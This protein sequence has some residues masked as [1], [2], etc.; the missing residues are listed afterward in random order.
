MFPGEVA[1]PYHLTSPTVKQRAIVWKY[2]RNAYSVKLVAPPL[3][4]FQ[5]QGKFPFNEIEIINYTLVAAE[6]RAG[7]I[8]YVR[9]TRQARRTIQ[10][11]WIARLR[12]EVRQSRFGTVAKPFGIA[13][14]AF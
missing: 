8:K 14:G 4:L 1:W 6:R 13:V 3:Y 7:T 2:L 10:R 9:P 5:S 12:Y 11:K